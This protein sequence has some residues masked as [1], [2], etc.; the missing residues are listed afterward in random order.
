[1]DAAGLKEKPELRAP[2]DGAA[3]T[4]GAPLP[5]AKEK[6]GFKSAVGVATEPN[7]TAD[8][9]VVVVVAF[10][11]A[12]GPPKVNA[13]GALD[14]ALGAPNVNGDGGASDLTAVDE[15]PNVN[16]DVALSDLTGAG[17]P[18]VKEAGADSAFFSS[19][20]SV[21]SAFFSDADADVEPPMGPKVNG[22]VAPGAPNPNDNFAAGFAADVIV[23]SSSSSLGAPNLRDL[24]AGVEPAFMVKFGF[25]GVSLIVGVPKV[26]GAAAGLAGVTG[27]GG[28]TDGGSME[29]ETEDVFLAAVVSSFFG[30]LGLVAGADLEVDVT[31]DS[32]DFLALPKSSIA[33]AC[34]L[35]IS[36]LCLPY[37]SNR[38]E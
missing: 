2:G 15:P 29:K 17:A 16:A 27:G 1:M 3:A 31:V 35:E 18:K 36:L 30:D 38:S 14:V 20:V 13:D 8:V 10:E 4:G 19:A 23:I 37:C 24:G 34:F 25:C 5:N 6:A 9:V 28:A 32:D 12:D 11:A 7:V 26:D 33:D 21:E 22:A